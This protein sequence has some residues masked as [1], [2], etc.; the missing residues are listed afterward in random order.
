MP[1][2]PDMTGFL[3]RKTSTLK[4]CLSLSSLLWQPTTAQRNPLHIFIFSYIE[5]FNSVDIFYPVL[6]FISMET[7]RSF[8]ARWRI[9]AAAYNLCVLIGQITCQ[10]SSLRTVNSECLF[11]SNL[12]DKIWIE[13]VLIILYIH[14]FIFILKFVLLE[15]T[16]QSTQQF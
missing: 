13:A 5:S 1:C 15:C 7:G 3:V 6:I 16:F 10:S 2:M 9:E 12:F 8:R 4:E 11:N 14:I